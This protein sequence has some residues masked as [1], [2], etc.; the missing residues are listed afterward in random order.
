VRGESRP[1]ERPL[2]SR[3]SKPWQYPAVSHSAFPAQVVPLAHKTEQVPVLAQR[4]ESVTVI[5]AEQRPTLH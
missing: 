5:S 4:V 3:D 2:A 1:P